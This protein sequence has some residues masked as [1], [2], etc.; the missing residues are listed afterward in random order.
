MD[1]IKIE[2]KKDPDRAMLNATLPASLIRKLVSEAPA[3]LSP[4]KPAKAQ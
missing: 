3:Q 2:Y 4:G 1:S